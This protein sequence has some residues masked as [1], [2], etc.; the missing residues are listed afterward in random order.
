MT[1]LTEKQKPLVDFACKVCF[2]KNKDKYGREAINCAFQ[3]FDN[4]Y[5]PYV[6]QALKGVDND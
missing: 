4:E 6:L 2:F 5:C 1:K 3:E